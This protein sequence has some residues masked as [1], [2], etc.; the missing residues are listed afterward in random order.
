VIVV[1]DSNI[2]FSALITPKG[3]SATIYNAWQDRH[4]DLVTSTEQIEEIRGA[5]RNKKLAHILRP[6]EVGV[7][8]NAIRKAT[9]LD[10]VPRR[11]G[12]EDPT[13]S[14]LLNLAAAASAHFLVSGDKRSGLLTRRRIEST[15]ILTPRLFCETV[16]VARH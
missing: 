16:L 6:R 3:Y 8:L 10:Q 14:F 5:S 11:F 4:F 2:F 13:D 15:R 12:A 7:M 1:L 9:V